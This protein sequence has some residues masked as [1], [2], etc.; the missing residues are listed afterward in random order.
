MNFLIWEISTIIYTPSRIFAIFFST[1]SRA[2]ISNKF[3]RRRD[4]FRTAVYSLTAATLAQPQTAIFWTG[5][6]LFS[7]TAQIQLRNRDIKCKLNIYDARRFEE[8]HRA[9]ACRINNL[10]HRLLWF[11]R[12]IRATYI[13]L[14]VFRVRYV[15]IR[16]LDLDSH[17]GMDERDVL[18]A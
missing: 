1:R 2:A 8:S 13:L 16:G 3:R 7:A 15:R 18:H 11:I 5:S 4:L 10:C 17:R 6:K 9:A 14:H 12:L